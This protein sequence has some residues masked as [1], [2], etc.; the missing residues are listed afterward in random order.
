MFLNDLIFLISYTGFSAD[1]NLQ[2]SGFI[3]ASLIFNKSLKFLFISQRKS[4]DI[5]CN[6][7]AIIRPYNDGCKSTF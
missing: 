3:G 4:I 2:I 6:L 1:Y 7:R 5:Y